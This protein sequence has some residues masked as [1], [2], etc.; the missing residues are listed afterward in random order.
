MG[1][2]GTHSTKMAGPANDPQ[3]GKLTWAPGIM[4]TSDAF[5]QGSRK[6]TAVGKALNTGEGASAA[7]VTLRGS[8][9]VMASRL[10][11]TCLAS[12]TSASIG[13]R[14]KSGD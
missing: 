2:D 8:L 10:E 6:G 13:Y 5:A 11:D 9:N 3:G 12:L 7:A 1:C 14:V 4:L